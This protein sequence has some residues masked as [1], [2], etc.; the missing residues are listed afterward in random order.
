MIE[1]TQGQIHRLIA[2]GYENSEYPLLTEN[3]FNKK[4]WY[5][6]FLIRDNTWFK[7]IINPF[8][9][10]ENVI[11]GIDSEDM[12]DYW[13]I[14]DFWDAKEILEELLFLRNEV[15]IM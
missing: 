13:Y 3:K 12:A 9:R 11:V 10:T 15:G 4:P 2:Q 6:K 7:I 14:E 5:K 1:L 8:E